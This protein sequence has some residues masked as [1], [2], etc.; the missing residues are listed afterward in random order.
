MYEIYRTQDDVDQRLVRKE[1]RNFA[2]KA[3]TDLHT[4]S[5]DTEYLSHADRQSDESDDW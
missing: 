4:A 2:Q 5:I 1:S 3:S